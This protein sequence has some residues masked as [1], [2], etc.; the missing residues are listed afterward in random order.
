MLVR[1]LAATPGSRPDNKLIDEI[2]QP[3]AQGGWFG[4]YAT[5]E[6]KHGFIQWIMPLRSRSGANADSQELFLHE[7]VAMR[8]DPVVKTRVQ[9][10]YEVSKLRKM[11][12]A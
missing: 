12:L 4:D 8:S 7:A 11:V 2:L 5:L 3:Q 9:R 10:A 6:S 1:S